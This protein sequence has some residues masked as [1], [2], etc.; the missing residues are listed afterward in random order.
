M[1]ASPTVIVRVAVS[2][3]PGAVADLQSEDMHPW[4]AD[5][6][7]TQQPICTQ[8]LETARLRSCFACYLDRPTLSGQWG[9]HCLAIDRRT[10]A[11][12]S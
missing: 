7:V 4:A 3:P 2:E 6:Y 10:V 5:R 12:S 11:A 9:G 1:K 8:G